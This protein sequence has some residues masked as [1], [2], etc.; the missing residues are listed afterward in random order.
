MI[1]SSKALVAVRPRLFSAVAVVALVAGGLSAHGVTVFQRSAYSTIDLAA[2]VKSAAP[3]REGFEC[4]GLPGHPIFVAETASHA[5]VAASTAP[6]R[7][8]AAEQTLKAENSPFNAT[9]KRATIEWRI[10]IRDQKPVP[11][12]TIMRFFTKSDGGRGEVLVVM[13]VAGREACHVAYID[14]VATKDAIV[15]ARQIA[16]EK[17]R[18]FDCKQSPEIAGVRGKSPM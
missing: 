18:S 7:S 4:K 17:A 14:A 10:V 3:D 16:D 5:Y 11:Y 8:R 9:S 13:R 1:G 12:A 15:L 6:S 2:C